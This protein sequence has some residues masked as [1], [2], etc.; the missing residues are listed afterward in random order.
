MF[1]SELKRGELVELT[2]ERDF[3]YE[4]WMPL[5]LADREG[6]RG[7]LEGGV[8]GQTRY[9]SIDSSIALL[10]GESSLRLLPETQH[11]DIS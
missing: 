5:A 7:V 9:E 4:S 6:D 8:R 11:F 10:Y 1:D 2:L 3:Q